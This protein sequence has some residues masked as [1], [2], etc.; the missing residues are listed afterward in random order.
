MPVIKIYI[1]SDL[2][3]RFCKLAKAKG[4]SGSEFYRMAVQE[5]LE[6]EEKVNQTVV[7]SDTE[8]SCPAQATI[9]MPNFLK[10]MGKH[11]AKMKGMT[12]SRWV[13]SL[14]QSNL[15]RLPVMTKKEIYALESSNREL[16]AIGRNINQIARTLNEAF[17]KTEAVRLEKLAELNCEI[18]KN[19][20]TIHELIKASH[21][22]WSTD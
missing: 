17:Y 19:R 7:E 20:K 6:R 10:E 22:V 1:D 5:I 15:M 18:A 2:K 21:N 8:N 14:I 3:N 11:K 12:F 13:A 9:R 4:L 16:A